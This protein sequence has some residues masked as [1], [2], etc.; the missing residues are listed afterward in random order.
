MN[1]YGRTLLA[2]LPFLVASA[3]FAQDDTTSPPPTP[4]QPGPPSYLIWGLF[5]AWLVTVALVLWRRW[6]RFFAGG[7]A[8]SD[9]EQD[10]AWFA[11]ISPIVRLRRNASLFPLPLTRRDEAIVLYP[12]QLVRIR[13]RRNNP[14]PAAYR[15]DGFEELKKTK[16]VKVLFAFPFDSIEKIVF[17]KPWLRGF[18]L[19]LVRMT[20]YSSKKKRRIYLR[21]SDL[22]NLLRAL[23]YLLPGTGH[24]PNT[25]ATQ[26]VEETKSGRPF[27]TP[28]YAVSPSRPGSETL[29]S[30]FDRR[31]SIVL[32]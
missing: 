14:I 28:A 29:V 1:R 6:P 27:A 8:V 11:R 15:P 5:I 26:P 2:L 32:L 23:E 13:L 20:V 17:K 24:T 12:S 10:S 3:L 18:F 21:G 30:S 16:G 4:A 9:G 25:G 19:N 22:P 7:S 31:R